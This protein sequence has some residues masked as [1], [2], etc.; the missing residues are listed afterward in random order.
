MVTELSPELR[1]RSF[2]LDK[3]ELQME[4]PARGLLEPRDRVLWEM[5]NQSGLRERGADSGGQH[6]G[7]QSQWR[8]GSSR[9]LHARLGMKGVGRA[10]G[11]AETQGPLSSVSGV[12]FQQSAVPEDL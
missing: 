8:D 6:F 5:R 9:G 11:S 4:V 2:V 3:L 12:A 10:E 7:G 1:G